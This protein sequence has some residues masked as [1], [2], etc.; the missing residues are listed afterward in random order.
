MKAESYRSRMLR[1]LWDISSNRYFC[2]DNVC[3]TL[4]KQDN[5]RLNLQY[6]SS[7]ASVVFLVATKYLMKPR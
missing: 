5:Q 4:Y 7:T 2:D 3:V 1:T 6:S